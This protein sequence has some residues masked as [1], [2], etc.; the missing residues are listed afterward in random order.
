[1]L[2]PTRVTSP[3]GS[4]TGR[5]PHALARTLL[6]SLILPA[7]GLL[8][9]CEGTVHRTESLAGPILRR[10]GGRP[11]V[12]RERAA[13][14]KRVPLVFAPEVDALRCEGFDGDLRILGSAEGRPELRAH[15]RTLAGDRELAQDVLSSIR[16]ETERDGQTLVARLVLPDDKLAYMTSSSYELF[17]P[18]GMRVR[19]VNESGNV[20]VRGAFQSASV[21][22]SFGNVVLADIVGNVGVQSDSGNVF[23]ERIDGKVARLVSTYGDITLSY[24]RAKE[25]EVRTRS[26]DITLEWVRALDARISTSHGLIDAVGHEGS[27]TLRTLDSSLELSATDTRAPATMR[28]ERGEVACVGGSGLL[29]IRSE[30][31]RVRVREFAGTVVVDSAHGNV[32]LG[33]V[34]DE[35]RAD[36]GSGKLSV[37]AK[38]GSTAEAAWRLRAGFGNV[39]LALPASFAC[40]LEA[41]TGKGSIRSDFPIELDASS[42]GP[43]L[44]GLLN[45]GG[46]R[47]Q[48]SSDSGRIEIQRTGS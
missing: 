3:R 25:I 16:I 32:D 18:L 37:A 1:M 27:A 22:T 43:G 26:G 19:V 33:G 14:L 35:V 24:V 34:F 46:S 11:K 4:A 21:V 9:G 36:S 40:R 44:H 20:E 8:S 23:A 5:V 29:A 12:V 42:G 17:V 15:L 47:V 39:L 10:E 38:Q 7:L 6:T 13:E 45:G 28:A 31:G 41:R 30:Y 48:V 2:S